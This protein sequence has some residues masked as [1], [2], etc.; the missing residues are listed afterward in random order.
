MITVLEGRG[1]WEERGNAGPFQPQL[2]L[3]LSLTGNYRGNDHLGRAPLPQ[4]AAAQEPT[5]EQDVGPLPVARQGRAGRS[6]GGKRPAHDA[7]RGGARD[8]F[9]PRGQ[10]SGLRA[11]GREGA[12]ARAVTLF[13]G[14]FPRRRREPGALRPSSVTD[15]RQMAAVFRH[16]FGILFQIQ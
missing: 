9:R 14:R 15:G 1:R 6:A 5:A 12:S 10:R 2:P 3:R 8:L 7:G 4:P 13:A 16:L 11:R